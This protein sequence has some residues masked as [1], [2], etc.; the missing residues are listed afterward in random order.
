[1]G[2][3]RAVVTATL[4]SIVVAAGASPAAAEHGDPIIIPAP[5]P[6][7]AIP[8]NARLRLESHN[9]IASPL[10]E[11]AAKTAGYA[12]VLVASDHEIALRPTAFFDD[13]EGGYGAGLL[14][15]APVKLLQPSTTYALELRWP[16]GAARD[17][18]TGWE[19]TTLDAADRAA[20]RWI[21]APRPGRAAGVVLA[22]PG[23]ES[24]LVE[25]VADL[26]PI[27][28][29]RAKRLHLVFDLTRMCDAGPTANYAVAIANG[30]C[31]ERG[32]EG[33]CQTA[34]WFAAHADV[35][36]RFRARLTAIDLAGNRTAAPGRK[37]IVTWTDERSI[38]VCLPAGPPPSA[39]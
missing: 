3:L 23:P 27:G 6:G 7:T 14:V 32:D 29:G 21:G 13:Q 38:T 20:P 2:K 22:D 1:M 28:R 12:A 17:F 9:G 4:V 15:L 26:T 34:H 24:P 11:L 25:I 37:P 5:S 39:P 30:S 18:A 19:W 31:A 33:L 8:I 16:G 35:G 36:R 10:P